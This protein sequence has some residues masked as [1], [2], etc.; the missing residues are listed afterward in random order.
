VVTPFRAQADALEEAALRAFDV[1]ELEALDLRV[2]TVHAFQGNERDVVIASLGIGPGDGGASWRFVEDPHLFT[3]FVTRARRRLIFVFSAD[4]AEGGLVDAYLAQ[5]DSPPGT[6]TPAGAVSAWAGAVA[7]DLELAGVAVTCAYP[8]GRHVVDICL[9][10]RR[11]CVGI[12]CDLHPDG[13]DA[14]IERHLDLARRGW[15]LLEAHRSRWH[16]RRA[17]LIV[18]LVKSFGGGD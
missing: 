1:D 15:D 11:R 13:P 14:H 2:G 9:D 8:S 17:E 5:A 10:D 16:G 3:V 12:E 18:A 7:H 4:P 6:P